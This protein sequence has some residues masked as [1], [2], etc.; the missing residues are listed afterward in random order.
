MPYTPLQ[1]NGSR[2]AR[3][4][5]SMLDA[6]MHGIMVLQPILDHQSQPQDF[7]V[8]AANA[9]IKAQ[10]GFGIDVSEKT[11]LSN[12]FPAYKKHGFFK[13]YVDALRSGQPQRQELFYSDGQ[14]EGW[15]DIGV[16]PEEDLLV[17]T[18]VNITE[19]K[20]NQ[21]RREE[22]AQQL[23]AIMDI[24]QAGI[25]TFLPVRDDQGTVVD[26]RFGVVNRF[27]A[28]YVGQEPETLI[29][30]LGSKWFP[31]YKTNGLFEYYR[32]TYE[33]GKTNRFDF[34]YN[35]DGIDVWLDIQS[36]PQ[37]DGILVTYTDYT[38]AKKLQLQLEK[39]VTELSRSNEHLEEF[40]YA[41]S[42]DLQEPL[43]KIHFF[44]NH[45]K[46]RYQE[47]L[48]TEGASLLGRMENATRRMRRLIDDLL[49]FSRVSARHAQKEEVCLDDVLQEVLTD[50]ETRVSE[51]GAALHYDP[52]PCLQGD[53]SQFRQLFQ[54]LLGNALKYV[55]AG[56]RPEI[57]VRCVVMPGREIRAEWQHKQQRATYY[58]IDVSDN[59]LGF[60]PEQAEKIF[61]LFHRLHG[62]SEFEGTGIGL[63]IVQKVAE[64]HKGLVMAEGR[65]GEGAV[66]SVFLPKEGEK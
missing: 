15:F 49:A 31:A 10:V 56:V 17:V 61:Q 16:A 53:R 46:E 62:R 4:L 5:Q 2:P 33:T 65:P 41:A 19:A 28:A 26:F 47:A 55:R 50:L 60:E 51:S 9:A 21:Q 23:E 6:S 66:F 18:F 35:A 43:R 25:F 34:H 22:T 7:T 57:G 54:N 45:L 32:N 8:E 42:H 11:L 20:Q 1:E 37:R 13:F 59:G 12:V 14:L 52:L 63:A 27:F 44:S 64:N 3:L 40:A 39:M 29:N 24:V 30:D 58:R 48:G 36:T 38:S